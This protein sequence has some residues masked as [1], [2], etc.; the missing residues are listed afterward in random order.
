VYVDEPTVDTVSN[1]PL[2]LFVNAD[3]VLVIVT[4]TF[5]PVFVHK[6]TLSTAEARLTATVPLAV[7]AVVINVFTPE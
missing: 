2:K 1:V 4:T 6:R 3:A 7:V 5:E